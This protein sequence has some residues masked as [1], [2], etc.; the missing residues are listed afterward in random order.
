V[1]SGSIFCA[2]SGV[3]LA[4]LVLNE[5]FLEVFMSHQNVSDPSFI[6]DNHLNGYRAIFVVIFCVFMAL[7]VVGQIFALDWRTWLPGAEGSRATLV[8]VK[9]AVYTVI[10]QLS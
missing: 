10:S 1:G 7:A 9:S 8:S 6:A 2:Q 4:S 3:D 5:P